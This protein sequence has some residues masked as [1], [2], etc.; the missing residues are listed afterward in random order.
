MNKDKNDWNKKHQVLVINEY[1]YG[2]G[3]KQY[4]S[5]LYSCTCC[6]QWN[7]Q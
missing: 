4:K 7:L 2:K 3:I 1:S 6:G 5:G